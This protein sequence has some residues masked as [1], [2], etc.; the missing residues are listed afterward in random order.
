MGH[1]K[2]EISIEFEEIVVIR[3][4]D[5]PFV[6]WCGDCGERVP[7]LAADLAARIA[8]VSARTIFRWVEAGRLHFKENE[9]GSLLICA[10]SLR[11]ANKLQLEAPTNRSVRADGND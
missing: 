5:R 8:R 9:G 7:M 3:S 4:P 6:S 11:E 10:I 2:R 1:R